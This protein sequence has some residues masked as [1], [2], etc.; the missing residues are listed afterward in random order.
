MT[1]DSPTPGR[2]AGTSAV[3]LL[4]AAAGPTLIGFTGA[5]GPFW[6]LMLFGGIA[7]ILGAIAVQAVQVFRDSRRIKSVAAEREDMR[8]Q[9]RDA[10][11]PI[12]ELIAQ[13]PALG[14]G[15]RAHR[16]QGIAQACA[17][18]LYMLVSP[19]AEGV[20]AN[21]FALE[22]GPDRMEWLAHVGRGET[23]RPFIAGTPRGD[24]ALVFITELKPAFYP[25]LTVKQPDGYEGSMS[26]YETFVAVPIWSDQAVYGMVTIDAPT[27]NALTVGD[28]YLVEVV[29][30]IMAT[31]FVV[32]NTEP[33]TEPLAPVGG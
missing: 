1:A 10:L 27:K 20:R 21:L 13:L 3:T 32:A 26:D 9:V 30:E 8:R 16:L 19:H 7:L 14:Y 29:A 22:E 23:P 4:L 5:V 17:T 11:K 15:D 31:A 2:R 6:A 25:D 33:P 12:P 24:S 28:Q 18:A